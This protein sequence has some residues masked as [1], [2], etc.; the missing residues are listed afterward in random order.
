MLNVDIITD[1]SGCGKVNWLMYLATVLQTPEN[2]IKVD[3][4]MNKPTIDS[5]W[6]YL[7]TSNDKKHCRQC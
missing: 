2:E 5:N 1:H 7:S 4:S 6:M 3:K